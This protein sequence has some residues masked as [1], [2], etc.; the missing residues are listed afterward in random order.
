[1]SVVTLAALLLTGFALFW[2]TR[3]SNAVSVERQLR[4]TERSIRAIVGELSQQQEMV[5]IWD[6]A[7]E[8][9]NKPT[10]DWQWLDNNMGVWLAKTFGQDQVYILDPDNQPFYAVVDKE[11]VSIGAFEHVR[12]GLQGMIHGLRQDAQSPHAEHAREPRTDSYLTTG[13]AVSDAH[14]LELLGRPAAVSV[15]KIVPESDEV[16]QEAGRE[17]LLVGIRFL[18][19]SFIEQISDR[20]L[21]DGLRFSRWNTSTDGEI[22]VPLT[23]DEGS[24]IGYFLWRPELPGLRIL[25]LVGPVAALMSLAIVVVMI[26]LVRSLRLSASQQEMTIV[27]LRASRAQAQHLAFHDV[28]T[29]LPNRAYFDDR[30]DQAL[31]RIGRRETIAVL[32]IDLDRFK[33]VNDNLGHQ[34]GDSLIREFANRLSGLLRQGDTVARLGGDEFAVVQAGIS[35]QDDVDALCGRILASV[36][37]P[38]DV[39]GHQV[40]VGAS[41]GIALAPECGVDRVELMRK[42]DIALYRAKDEGRNCSR[43]FN[44]AMDETVRVRSTIEDEL[45][46][47]LATGEGLNVEYQPQVAVSG[48]SIVGLETLVRWRH[49]TRGPILPEQFIPVA[50]Q[51][52]L[53]APL[54]EWVL[55]QACSASRQWPDLFVSVN[56]SPVQFRADGFAERVIQIV[57]ECGADPGRIELEVTEGVLLDERGETANGLKTLRAAGFRIALDDFGTGYSSLGYLHRFAVDKIKID[58]SFV[59]NVG[60]DANAAAIIKSIVALGQ[61][62]DLTVTAEGVETENQKSFLCTAGCTEMQGFLFSKAVPREQVARL[63]SGPFKAQPGIVLNAVPAGA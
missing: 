33:H 46:A 3:E 49:P 29:G 11:R 41:I 39:L 14:L 10:P 57:R 60:Q 7:I 9:L 31:A 48:R 22:S 15:M 2:A 44:A 17:F 59:K 21:V 18:D 50:E 25:N 6:D 37:K 53:I 36:R 45:R 30:L 55:R 20:N 63:L 16:A 1:V 51:T 5:A 13:K 38:F 19:G 32:M 58:R 34:A 47:A 27:E 61:A 43:V 12:L 42:A 54:G 24:L 62:L 52:G 8:E 4:T 35:G 26:M 23:S 40:F 28:L 56:L